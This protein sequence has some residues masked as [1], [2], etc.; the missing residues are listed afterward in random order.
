VA[1]RS[2]PAPPPQRSVTFGDSRY[3]IA[4]SGSLSRGMARLRVA[5]G[6]DGLQMWRVAA[7]VLNK[8]WRTADKGGPALWVWARG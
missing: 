7:N 1:A 8:Q 4:L 5:D 6:R 2:P 3:V